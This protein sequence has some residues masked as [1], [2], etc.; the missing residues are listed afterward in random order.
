MTSQIRSRIEYMHLIPTD[1][2]LGF[3]NAQIL[4][5]KTRLVGV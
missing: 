4:F 3:F 2:I 5:L 1:D